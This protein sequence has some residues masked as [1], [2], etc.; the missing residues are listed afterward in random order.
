MAALTAGAAAPPVH[1]PLVSGGKFDLH[2]ALARGPVL[3][4]F[5]K[6]SCPI[7]QFAFPY[8]ERIHRGAEASGVTI[9][10]VSQND[11]S[12]TKQFIKEFGLTFPVALDRTD[13]YPV[14]NAYGLTNVPTFF[15]IEPSGTIA[16]S[17]VS[18]ARAEVEEIAQRIAAV[19]KQPLI[20]LFHPG[21]N[22]P[23]WKPG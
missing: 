7:C 3:L 17:S 8:I 23:A 12:G 20:A 19:G 10:G 4:A 2:A 1:L 9:V 13:S 21:E 22:V 18:W 5:F 6:I 14:S 16:V 15:Y 11:A